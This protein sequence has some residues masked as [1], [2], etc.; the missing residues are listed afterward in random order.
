M[1]KIFEQFMRNSKIDCKKNQI[2]SKL[3]YEFELI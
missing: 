2:F 3:F 1:K